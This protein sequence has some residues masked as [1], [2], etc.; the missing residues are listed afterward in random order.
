MI[1]SWLEDK[2]DPIFTHQR[3]IRAS[4]AVSFPCGKAAA[5]QRPRPLER[6]F[7]VEITVFPRRLPPCSRGPLTRFACELTAVLSVLAGPIW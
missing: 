2:N 7:S 5:C 4:A 6:A 3:Q 1:L